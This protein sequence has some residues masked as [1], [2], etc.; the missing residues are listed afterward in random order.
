[1]RERPSS[2][3]LSNELRH[4][5]ASLAIASGAGI[6]VVQQIHRHKSAAVGRQP[7]GAF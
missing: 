1:M 3:S 7:A 6:K 2:R 5:A 4:T